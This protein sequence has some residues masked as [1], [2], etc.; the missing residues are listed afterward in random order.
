MTA[1][2][3]VTHLRSGFI[4]DASSC[5]TVCTS[6][7]QPA[8]HGTALP[9][10]C[11]TFLP[12]L[13]LSNLF[14]LHHQCHSYRTVCTYRKPSLPCRRENII[15]V[16]PTGLSVPTG[17]HPSLAGLRTSL[18]SDSDIGPHVMRCSAPRITACLTFGAYP[19][20]CFLNDTPN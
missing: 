12:A 18:M 3:R 9:A 17:N 16:T 14:R 19:T 5:V 15:N 11:L 10:S 2:L 4:P 13:I 20:T 7:N 1:A 6:T 8:S